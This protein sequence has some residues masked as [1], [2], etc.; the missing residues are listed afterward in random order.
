MQLLKSWIREACISFG[1]DLS[2]NLKYDRLTRIILKTSLKTDSNCIDVGCHKGEILHFILK[3]APQGRHFAFEPIP[4]FYNRL[5]T[6]FG[7]KAHIYPFALSDS[8]GQTTFNWVKNAPAFS[9]LKQ[10]TYL[11]KNPDIEVIPVKIRML[12]ELIPQ[13]VQIDFIKIDVEGGEFGVLRGASNLILRCKPLIMFES[14]TGSSEF[15][16]TTPQDL[17]H[18]IN[19][20]LGLKIFTLEGFVK[21]ENPLSAETFLDLYQNRGEFCFMAG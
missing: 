8:N 14:G 10:R 16:G 18:F 17:Y 15:Y 6:K 21:K 20:E 2:K 4:T 19:H 7:S 13:D 1:L 12:D 11:V 3:Y 9:G 5:Q